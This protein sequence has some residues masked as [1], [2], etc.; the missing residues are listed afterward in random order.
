MSNE[1]TTGVPMSSE[2][3]NEP[4]RRTFAPQR[5]PFDADAELVL[6]GLER[7]VARIR[8]ER[9]LH[10]ALTGALGEMAEAIAKAKMSL[11]PDADPSV[12]ALVDELEHRVDAMLDLICGGQIPDRPTTPAPQP[13]QAKPEIKPAPAGRVP[14]VSEVVSRLGGED[15]PAAADNAGAASQTEASAGVPTVAMLEAMVE[16][17]NASAPAA[18]AGGEN[19]PPEADRPK[20]P[21]HETTG[22][23]A[24][25]LP[26]LELPD[27]MPARPDALDATGERD[28][29]PLEAAS[30]PQPEAVHPVPQ[31][32]PPTEAGF[33]WVA[34]LALDLIPMPKPPP[35]S[36]PEPPPAPEPA[37]VQ[38]Q[39]G[40]PPANTGAADPLAAIMALSPE[41]KIALFS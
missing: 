23:I 17:M 38:P 16:A 21:R 9:S 41:E 10:G 12:T 8:G 31:P 7:I 36:P 2:A 19:T 24:P 18:A 6:T 5:E 25:P 33:D 11:P 39:P 40:A 35:E 34:A 32:P 14:T 15:V 26:A 30:V 20:S 3:S 27:A 28:A 4:S 22:E 13:P 1:P 37:I 29:K